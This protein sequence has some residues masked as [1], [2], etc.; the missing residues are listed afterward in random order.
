MRWVSHFLL[1]AMAT[2]C[3]P[4]AIPA[5]VKFAEDEVLDAENSASATDLDSTD[6][7]TEV[8][9]SDGGSLPDTTEGLDSATPPADTSATSDS[10][11]TSDST[12]P[13]AATKVCPRTPGC[14]NDK[15]CEPSCEETNETCPCD[16]NFE[17]ASKWTFG[18]NKCNDLCE[19]YLN[20][21]DC[22]TCGD[23][24]CLNYGVCNDSTMCIESGECFK[25]C[26]NKICEP[27]E[28]TSK[29]ALK[30]GQVVCDEDCNNS[31]CGNDVCNF[32]ENPDLCAK[33]CGTACGNCVCEPG[34]KCE[35]DCPV[36]GDG[37]CTTCAKNDESKS[38]PAD[39][40]K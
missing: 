19:S 38:C 32:S 20:S 24:K 15:K 27:G 36:C 29:E 23:S 22:C 18:D 37:I 34:E 31:A 1:W 3:A 39:C 5:S 11:A 14:N 16:C 4:I 33:D 17:I 2:G 13:D 40:K 26:G 7:A 28:T 9:G 21:F 8:T 12:S 35:V 30:P 6:V 25:A 10:V